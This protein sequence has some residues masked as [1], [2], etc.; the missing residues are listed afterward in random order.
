MILVIGGRSK[1]GSA[2]IAELLERGRDVRALSRASELATSFP[3]GVE[4]GLQEWMI[5]GLVSLFADYR[6]SGTRGY[7]ARTSDAVRQIT[8]NEPRTLDGLL[9]E[10]QATAAPR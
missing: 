7:A 1:I 5:S 4:L 2:L 8:G 3:S 6:H 10:A 9:A